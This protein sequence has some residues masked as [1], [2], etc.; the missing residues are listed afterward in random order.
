[1][2][3][4]EEREWKPEYE[5]PAKTRYFVKDLVERYVKGRDAKLLEEIMPLKEWYERLAPFTEQDEA[6]R[7]WWGK[8]EALPTKLWRALPAVGPFTL[9][10]WEL[11]RHY[12]LHW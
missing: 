8:R 4:D 3:A 7:R 1:M 2:P 11:F 9:M 12:V 5:V 6:M 10:A